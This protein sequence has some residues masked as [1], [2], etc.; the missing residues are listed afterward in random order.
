MIFSTKK[1]LNFFFHLDKK[2]IFLLFCR[3]NISVPETVKILS[4]KMYLIWLKS[5]QSKIK[6]FLKLHNCVFNP[7]C[8]TILSCPIASL[9]RTLVLHVMCLSLASTAPSLARTVPKTSDV[10]ARGTRRTV[11]FLFSAQ[12]ERHLSTFWIFTQYLS[13]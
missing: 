1:R 13:T 9:A 12:S 10:Q 11:F 4:L 6:N 8:G 7:L 3:N 2:I 5:A